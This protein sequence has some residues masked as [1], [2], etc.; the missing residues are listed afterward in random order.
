MRYSDIYK[1]NTMDYLL[2]QNLSGL[3]AENCGIAILN[4]GW[5]H[6]KRNID[7]SVLILGHQGEVKIQEE[8]KC[9]NI[10]P[11]S[12]CILSEGNNHWGAEKIKEKA[13]YYW[14]HFK[15][16]EKPQIVSEKEAHNILQNDE[17]AQSRLKNSLLLPRNMDLPDTKIIREAF[18]ELLYEQ[19]NRLFTYQKYQYNVKLMLIDLNLMVFDIIR[20]K[21]NKGDNKSLVNK[22]IQLIYENLTDSNFSVKQLADR[23][24]YNPD[25]LN[26]HFK[27]IMKISLIEYII[28]KRIEY[29]LVPLIDSEETITVIAEN[30]GFSSYR[31]YIQQFK[32]RKLATPS[33]YRNRHRMIHIT[34]K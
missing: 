28:D 10:K 32:Q 12:F 6:R 21:R 5:I 26:R 1:G 13:R 2:L 29:S 25:Y 30:S 4:P 9:Y 15:T 17:I 31:N 8:E 7:T 27:S 19:D 33:E 34:N 20:G 18:H 3:W 14:I 22:I 16:S 24:C 11:H 23:L